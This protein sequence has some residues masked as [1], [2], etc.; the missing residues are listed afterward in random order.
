MRYSLTHPAAYVSAN[1]VRFADILEAFR[2]TDVEH[3]VFASSSTVYGAKTSTP[4]GVQDKAGLPLSLYAATKKSDELMAHV[5]AHL[6]G[7]PATGFRLFLPYTDRGD[8]P[9]RRIS[10]SLEKISADEA[11]DVFNQGHHARDLNYI[12]DIVEPVVR[13]VDRISQPNPD[14]IR[15]TPD[16]SSSSAPYPIYNVGN[17]QP[18]N[19][20]DF[21]TKI[22]NAVGWKTR[23]NDLPM[24]PG[25][26]IET[27]A[28]VT[29]LARDVGFSPRTTID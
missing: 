16:H 10:S 24:Q 18:L 1:L 6:Y 27:F 26:V 15:A 8:G 23:K 4:F 29:D 22:E 14:W 21:I 9:T 12:D 17:S 28:D 2:Y 11:I 5:Y 7:P 19:L 13:V 20:I 25:D 3:V